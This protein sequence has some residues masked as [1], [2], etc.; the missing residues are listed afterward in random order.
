MSVGVYK[1]MKCIVKLNR[2]TKDSRR[3]RE[4]EWGVLSML[5][6]LFAF[7]AFSFALA[8]LLK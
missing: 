8:S 7:Y 6:K 5:S 2:Q 3:G 1:L 4:S